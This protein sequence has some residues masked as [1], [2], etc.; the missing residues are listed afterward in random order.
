M[1]KLIIKSK[2]LDNSLVKMFRYLKKKDNEKLN[3][4]LNYISSPGFDFWE[5]AFKFINDFPDVY[6]TL[7]ILFLIDEGWNLEEDDISYLNK[8]L[9]YFPSFLLNSKTDKIYLDSESLSGRER[10]NYLY[11]L[12]PG[13]KENIPVITYE[14]KEIELNINL[15]LPSYFSNILELFI[16]NTLKFIGNLS[17]INFS[18]EIKNNSKNI[19]ID[20]EECTYDSKELNF[21]SSF[22]NSFKG[23]IKAIILPPNNNENFLKLKNIA[24]LDNKCKIICKG[25]T[26]HLIPDNK[27]EFEKR[28]EIK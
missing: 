13:L 11:S 16:F 14:V 27:E 18:N 6:P 8:K 15:L 21:D 7:F 9:K 4:I 17:Q 20:F 19:I 3:N 24:S 22:F 26:E 10:L 23:N 2:E 25:N 1:G 5:A 28:L 12:L